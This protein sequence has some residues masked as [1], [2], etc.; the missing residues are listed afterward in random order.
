M[1]NIKKINIPD[2]YEDWLEQKEAD[3]VMNAKQNE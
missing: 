2:W 1:I 3:E